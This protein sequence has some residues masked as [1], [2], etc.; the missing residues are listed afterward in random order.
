MRKVLTGAVAATTITAGLLFVGA[1][2]NAATASPRP[3]APTELSI[4]ESGLPGRG[5]PDDRITGTLTQ[6]RKTLAGEVVSLDIV[7]RGR[8]T[9]VGTARTNRDGTVSFTVTPKGSTT[10]TLVFSGT[11]VL[12]AS[13]SGTVTVQAR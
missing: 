3:Q 10:Y 4:H 5:R 9:V 8:P 2:A 13:Q 1:T 11:P 6:G 7:N 12:A